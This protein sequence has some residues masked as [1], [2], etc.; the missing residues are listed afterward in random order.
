MIFPP[1]GLG[2]AGV[3]LVVVHR[4]ADSGKERDS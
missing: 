1:S 2:G 3:L 4:I